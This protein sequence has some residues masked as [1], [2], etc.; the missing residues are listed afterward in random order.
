MLLRCAKKIQNMRKRTVYAWGLMAAFFTYVSIDDGSKFH[1]R[2]GS[3]IGQL[4]ETPMM[5]T[6]FSAFPS[7]P[8]QVVFAPVFGAMGLL[9]LYVVFKEMN[10]RIAQLSVLGGLGCL[11]LAVGIDFLEGVPEYSVFQF[12][13]FLS[14]ANPFV[15]H[16][17]KAMEEFIEMAG[18]SFI[19]FGFFLHTLK[20]FPKWKLHFK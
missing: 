9:I 1:E 12:A 10:V 17:F 14:D 7:Y 2:I 15:R 20:A 3:T 18:M 19:F 16:Y 4:S 11:V 8:W 13:N 6:V 5:K